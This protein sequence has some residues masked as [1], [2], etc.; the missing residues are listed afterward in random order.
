[1]NQKGKDH[2]A[3]AS[4]ILYRTYEG[5]LFSGVCSRNLA[6]HTGPYTLYP[7][8]YITFQEF[9]DCFTLPL[10]LHSVIQN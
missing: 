8:P 2:S 1:M 4:G 7:G 3:W 9:L 10:A 6:S 5:H